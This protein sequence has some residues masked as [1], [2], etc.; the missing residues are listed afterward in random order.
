MTEHNA[1]RQSIDGKVDPATGCVEYAMNYT[2]IFFCIQGA[3]HLP[4]KPVLDERIQGEYDYTGGNLC[5][6]C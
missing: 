3:V 6:A 4:D 2:Y 5:P 1:T